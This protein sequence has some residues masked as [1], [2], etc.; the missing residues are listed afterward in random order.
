M[1][2]VTAGKDGCLEIEETDKGHLYYTLQKHTSGHWVFSETK[3]DLDGDIGA[4][5]DYVI[6]ED[7]SVLKDW[8]KKLGAEE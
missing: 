8:L 1:G 6:V 4:F 5:T 7:L 3:L 2:L